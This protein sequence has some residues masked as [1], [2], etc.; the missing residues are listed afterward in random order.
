MI[1]KLF[2][3]WIKSKISYFSTWKISLQ[4]I[5]DPRTLSMGQKQLIS[6]I[7][8][9]YLKK[10]IVLFDEISSG[11]DSQLEEAISK[12]LLIV[13]KNSLTFIVAHRLETVVK[14]DKILVMDK[15]SI[16]SIGNHNQL[17]ENS[18]LY[19]NLLTEFSAKM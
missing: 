13:Q 10:K 7:R 1:L 19:K 5:I 8:S 15:G 9:C 16:V 6:A 2:F 18:I 3:D 14:S 11:M 4:T 17:K 12:V